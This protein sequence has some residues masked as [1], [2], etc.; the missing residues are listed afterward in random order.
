MS[1]RTI[2]SDGPD[3]AG[4]LTYQSLIEPY[5]TTARSRTLEA[6]SWVGWAY[7][8]PRQALQKSMIIDQALCGLGGRAL[9]LAEFQPQLGGSLDES[10]RVRQLCRQYHN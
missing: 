3:I 1:T 7:S 4:R 6:K 5:V 8:K 10:R 2:Y 9:G